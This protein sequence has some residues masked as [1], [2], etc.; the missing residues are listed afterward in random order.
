[1]ISWEIH[2]PALWLPDEDLCPRWNWIMLPPGVI[3]LTRLYPGKLYIG[4]YYLTG[5]CKCLS[6]C[7]LDYTSK[8]GSFLPLG[9]DR[10]MEFLASLGDNHSSLGLLPVQ[11]Q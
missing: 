4:N 11:I 9:S 2:S 1:M 8:T 10:S 6:I 3:S 5:S 7:S